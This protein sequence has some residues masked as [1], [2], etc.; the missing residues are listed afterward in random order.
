MDVEQLL[1]L[2][3]EHKV[4]FVII[5]A[6]AFPV[7]GYSR[8]TLDI[9][10][11]IEPSTANARRTREALKAF[12]YDISDISV[13]DLLTYKVLIRQYVVET[14]IHPFVKGIGF[15]RVWANKVKAKLGETYAWF[16][17]LDDLIAM[18]Q[19]AGR[20]KDKEDLRYLRRLRQRKRQ[21]EK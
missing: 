2:L 12:G 18:K 5:G 7:H 20:P 3:R 8:S 21:A 14:D 9:D 16:A 13:E 19:A 1:K 4:R 17:S 11:F 10:I 15:D 6:T